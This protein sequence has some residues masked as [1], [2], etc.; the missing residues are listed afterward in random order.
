M[1]SSSPEG[2]VDAFIEDLLPDLEML[3]GDE[4]R[5]IIGQLC[6]KLDGYSNGPNAN[7]LIM[8]AVLEIELQMR[9]LRSHI[10]RETNRITPIRRGG[11]RM[12]LAR[13]SDDLKRLPEILL[14]TA[15]SLKTAI[16]ILCRDVITFRLIEP[17]PISSD[18]KLNFYNS[19]VSHIL[20]F[21]E[22]FVTSLRRAAEAVRRARAR[23]CSQAG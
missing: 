10:S 4:W 13:P 16:S 3:I 19:D 17:P 15:T 1:V 7:K 20:E 22:P 14:R 9:E 12:S 6:E 18:S 8:R 5:P 21:C 23:I 11:S 2:S